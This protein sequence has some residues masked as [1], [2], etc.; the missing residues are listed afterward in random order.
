M[1]ELRKKIDRLSD[2]QKGDALEYYLS[3]NR[4]N[5]SVTVL[6]KTID[7]FINRLEDTDI[8][9]NIDDAKDK[10]FDRASKL[11]KE[12]LEFAQK[13]EETKMSALNVEKAKDFTKKAAS[14]GVL[15]MIREQREQNK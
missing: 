6:E 7:D 1:S 15:A 10:T 2:E 3:D 13:L 4:I 8:T 5:R 14:N 9:S 12:L 11:I